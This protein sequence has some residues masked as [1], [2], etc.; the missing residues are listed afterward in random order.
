MPKNIHFIPV[1]KGSVKI[2]LAGLAKFGADEVVLF[3]PGDFRKTGLLVEALQRIGTPYRTANVGRRYLDAY[4]KANEEAAA[5]FGEDTSL[6][7]NMST[8]ADIIGGAIEDGVRMQLHFFHRTKEYGSCA[9][10]RYYIR[11]GEKMRF[12]TAPIWN[13]L[14]YLHND[15]M[16]V[17]ADSSAP[18]SMNQ[19][20]ENV[21]NL[22]PDESM[23]F[24]AFRKNFR[25]FKRWFGL[26]P[27]F[28]EVL[29]KSPLYKI[30][31]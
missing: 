7:V 13:F 15:M 21:R 29:R 26:N 2:H 16:E 10:Y 12:E 14:L 24:E 30:E 17:L 4:R 22:E 19:I 25:S 11:E 9:G 27:C 28:K 1:G 18:L 23:T 31:L 5:Y 8:G 3:S 20:L 6:G